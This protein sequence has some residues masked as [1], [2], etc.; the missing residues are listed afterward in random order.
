M[1]LTARCLSAPC[2]APY[3]WDHN[4]QYAGPQQL[5]PLVILTGKNWS[6]REPVQSHSTTAEQKNDCSYTYLF[7]P[8]G[9][10]KENLRFNHVNLQTNRKPAQTI[11]NVV[12][13]SLRVGR[14]RSQL[15]I[16]CVRR[17]FSSIYIPIQS[18][19]LGH[20]KV[21]KR[22]SLCNT[23]QTAINGLTVHRPKHVAA[24]I[25]NCL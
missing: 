2:N 14:E 8:F 19:F 7:F 24:N 3:K 11:T 17:V 13:L 9:V 15:A 20:V 6:E 1:V 23:I 5:V 4:T 22:L 21:N 16:W 25:Y 12:S 10:I 18:L